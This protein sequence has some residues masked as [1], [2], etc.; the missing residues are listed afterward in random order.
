MSKKNCKATPYIRENFLEKISKSQKYLDIRPWPSKRGNLTVNFEK[1][2]RYEGCFIVYRAEDKNLQVGI[3]VNHGW[4]TEKRLEV[5]NS[6]KFIL[7][8]DMIITYPPSSNHRGNQLLIFL[9]IFHKFQF[10]IITPPPIEGIF[11]KSKSFHSLA[12]PLITLICQKIDHIVL[13]WSFRQ[14]YW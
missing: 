13:D 10:I 4:V 6:L 8:H 2:W 3:P 12:N 14:Y 1:Y 5:S 9:E 11:Q 7:N